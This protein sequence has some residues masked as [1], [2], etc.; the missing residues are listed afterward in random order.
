MAASASARKR[1]TRQAHQ[2]PL[3]RLFVTGGGGRHNPTLTREIAARTGVPTQ[4]VEAVGWNGDALEAEAFA[5][6]AVRSVA[7]KAISWPET[8]GVPVAMTG[9]KRV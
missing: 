9:G 7:G 8:T 3:A 1:S 2:C 6:L 5:W 4:S